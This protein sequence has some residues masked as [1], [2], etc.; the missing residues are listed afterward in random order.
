MISGKL[1][2]QPSTDTQFILS[3]YSVLLYEVGPYKEV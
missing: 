1:T 3:Y 2:Q